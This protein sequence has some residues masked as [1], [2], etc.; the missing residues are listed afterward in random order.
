MCQLYINETG[1]GGRTVALWRPVVSKCTWPKAQ[2]S[3]AWELFLTLIEYRLQDPAHRDSD[4]S[5]LGWGQEI[6]ILTT[7]QHSDV[8]PGLGGSEQMAGSSFCHRI[9]GTRWVGKCCPLVPLSATLLH[10]E[11][12]GVEH[13]WSCWYF[14]GFLS[15]SLSN[16]WA[17]IKMLVSKN[18]ASEWQ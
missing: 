4:S 7:S 11:V 2:C 15:N 6:Y 9:L 18:V 12:T 16:A 5:S 8:R 17:L 3:V 13:W 14:W 1:V 10:S